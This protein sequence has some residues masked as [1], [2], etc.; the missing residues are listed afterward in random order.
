ML[1]KSR[2]RLLLLPYL[3]IWI[4]V[5]IYAIPVSS[6]LGHHGPVN[7]EHS[8]QHSGLHLAMIS[9]GV[10]CVLLG[11][12]LGIIGWTGL[13]LFKNWGRVSFA[14]YAVLRYLVVPL[15]SFGHTRLF[16]VAAF[17]IEATDAQIPTEPTLIAVID[18][19]GNLLEFVILVCIFTK[20]G[21]HLFRKESVLRGGLDA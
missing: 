18:Y 15:L 19:L 10:L 16:E 5:A 21:S 12:L 3:A 1:T 13:F 2:F 8:R 7:P 6:A 11:T 20:V 17:N 14:A 4:V 9:A